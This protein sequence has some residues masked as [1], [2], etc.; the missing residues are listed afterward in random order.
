MAR[1]IH[2]ISVGKVH[3]ALLVDAIAIYQKRLHPH[4]KVEWLLLPPKQETTITQNVASESNSILRTLE[5]AEYVFLCD[6]QGVMPTSEQF[7]QNVYAALASNKQVYFVIGG[8]HGVDQRVRTR[9]NVVIS[10]GKMVLPHQL[11]RLV[12]TEQL[13]RAATIASGSGYHHP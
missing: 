2:I 4:F 5:N 7:S 8:A 11:M 9:A 1:K 3:D 10:F 13:Y 6:E 12:L